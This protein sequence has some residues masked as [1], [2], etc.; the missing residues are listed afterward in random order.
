MELVEYESKSVGRWAFVLA[1]LFAIGGVGVLVVQGLEGRP[2][3]FIGVFLIGLALFLMN[4]G[5]L[6][7]RVTKAE[8]A[9]F[10]G[11]GLIGR[12]MK[13]ERVRG[14]EA[15]RSPWYWGWGI[16]WTPTGWLWRSYGLDVVWLEFDNGKRVGIGTQDPEGLVRAVREQLEL[17]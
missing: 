6:T 16:R 15:T 13:L 4:F 10:F 8:V 17:T 14:A 12:R 2:E 11:V 3:A 9:W 5:T 1:A 7:V